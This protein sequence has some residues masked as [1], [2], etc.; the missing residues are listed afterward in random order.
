MPNPSSHPSAFYSLGAVNT[1]I[2][3]DAILAIKRILKVKSLETY[4]IIL[5]SDLSFG[6]SL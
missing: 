3:I 6:G 5:Q 1:P 4:Q 2:I